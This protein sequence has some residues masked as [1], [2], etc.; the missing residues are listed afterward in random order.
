MFWLRN[1]KNNFPVR[2]LIWRSK[3]FC[4]LVCS[5]FWYIRQDGILYSLTGPCGPT[6]IMV[7]LTIR[8]TV[9]PVLSSRSKIDKTKVLKTDYR[10]M[11][12]KRE[13]SAIPL[14]CIKR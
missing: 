2:T 11:Q 14:T 4:K 7:A 1:K 8:D 10:L 5:P 6:T 13:H 9:K 3:I 12:V